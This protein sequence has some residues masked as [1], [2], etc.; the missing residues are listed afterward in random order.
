MAQSSAHALLGLINDILD[1]SKIEAGKLE[2]EAISFSLRECIA[3]TLKPL[4]MRADQKGLELTADIPADVPDHL[5]GDPMRLRQILINLIDNAIKFTE[6]GDVMLRVEVESATTSTV[7]F[8]VTDGGIGI[9]VAKQAQ[10]FE[11]FTQADGSTTRTHGGT[12]LGLA[13]ASRLVGQMGGRIWIESTVSVGTTF[14]FTARLP[15]RHTPVRARDPQIRG[16]WRG[17]VCSWS[18]TT[19]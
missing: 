8:S 5:I 13:I 2:L 9:P 19:P 17:F 18:M 6:R 14:H 12:G 7:H 4:G 11:A 3:T 10:M 1:F 15:V 16:S